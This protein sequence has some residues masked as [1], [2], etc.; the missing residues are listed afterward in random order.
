V[1]FDAKLLKGDFY[2]LYKTVLDLA[3]LFGLVGVALA[4]YRRM[5]SSRIVSTPTGVSPD[6][7]VA[8]LYFDHRA[9]GRGVCAGGY[10]AG[11]A[12]FSVVA[13]P[14]SLLFGSLPQDVLL[15]LHRGLWIFH[16]LGGADF[17]DAA[18]DQP[19]SHLH[20]AD[21]H[22]R[23]PF[24]VRG[25]LHPIQDLEQ[26]ETLGVSKLASTPGRGWSTWMRAPSAGDARWFVRLMPRISR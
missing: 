10:A 15:G 23:R 7:A 17:R 12:P 19:V 3:A 25:A 22:L 1:L 11:L 8:S 6:P 9:A 21:Q 24:R 14:V 4:A 20:V 26:A 13:Y 18:P 5:W 2:L 16:F